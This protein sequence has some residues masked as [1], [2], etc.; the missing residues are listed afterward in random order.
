[1]NARLPHARSQRGITLIGLVFWAVLISSAA[2]LAM[3]V[4]PTVNEYL[5]IKRVVSRIADS[6]ASTLARFVVQD[7]RAGPVAA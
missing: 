2:L 5:T 6:G 3:R 7:G 1:M 4:I